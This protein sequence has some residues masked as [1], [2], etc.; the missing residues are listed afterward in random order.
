M[1]WSGKVFLGD[2]ANEV[3]LTNVQKKKKYTARDVAS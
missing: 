3:R 1:S 2:G